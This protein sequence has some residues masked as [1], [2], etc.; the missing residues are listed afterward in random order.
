[1]NEE[2]QPGS[3]GEIT[4]KEAAQMCGG[5]ESVWTARAVKSPQ[6][7]PANSLKARCVLKS[8]QM[9]RQKSLQ[10]FTVFGGVEVIT[11]NLFDWK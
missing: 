7:V 6:W 9:D 4:L 1:M 10:R 2:K 3:Q 11:A 5:D 8:W